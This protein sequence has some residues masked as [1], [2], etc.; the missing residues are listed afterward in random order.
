VSAPLLGLLALLAAAPDVPAPNPPSNYW[1]EA[2]PEGPAEAALRDA[3]AR[4]GFGGPAA[5]VDALRQVSANYP[6]TAV[7]GLAQLAAGLALLE[8]PRPREAVPFLTHP[9]V[10]RTLLPDHALFALGRAQEAAD[11]PIEAARSYLAAADQGPK[12]AIACAALLRA[13]DALAKSHRLDQAADTLD[14]ALIA[15]PDQE[16]RIM[17]RLGEIQEERGARKAAAEAY[18][19]L[20]RDYP[21]STPAHDTALR[22]RALAPVLPAPAPERLGRELRKARALLEAGRNWEA[23]GVL[24]AAQALKT[25]GDDADLLHVRL[26]QALLALGRFREAETSLAGVGPKSPYAA[27]AAFDLARLS[28]RG[29]RTVE[30]YESVAERFP[31][32]PWAEEALL[33]LANH[34]QRDARDEEALPFYRRLLAEYPDGRYVERATWRTAWADYRAGRYEQAAQAL[35]RTARLRPPGTP[36][37]GFLYW[38]GRSRAALGQTERARL[39]FEETVQRYKYAYH[40]IRAREWLA[41]LPPAT[42]SVPSPVMAADASEP[43]EGIGEPA[44]TRVHQLLLIDRLDEAG[45]ELRA[46]P[47]SPRAEGT[48]AWIE[49]RC[50]RLRPAIT[51]MKRACPEWVGEAGDRLPPE[52][53]RI[54]FPLGFEDTLKAKAAEEGLDPALMAALILQESTFDAQALSRAGARG[55]MQVIPAT[56]RKLA[57]DL[58][59]RF[60]S[61]ALHNPKTSMDFGARYL[62]QMMDRYDGQAE[63]VLAA[64]NAGPHRVDAWTASRPD[65]PAEEFVESIPFTETRYYVMSVLAGREHYRRLYGLEMPARTTTPVAGGARP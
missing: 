60:R 62:R 2:K 3:L 53:W 41:R 22:L 44:A 50:G 17:E 49:W 21:A 57:R 23:V 26:G 19:R 64:Y 29:G 18:D 31:G 13:A 14:R 58:G 28:A 33:A 32:A 51:A 45:E 42:A 25:G 4:G 36:T 30:A 5:A 40:G 46:L 12:T 16:P 55:L 48:I 56:G 38:A 54:L 6:G 27:E 43:G 59:V 1:I 8:G 63:R 52:V 7:S 39:L 15:C 11:Q 24:R 20:D 35:E 37:P 65:M 47:F 9:D 34:Y 61:A 10:Q